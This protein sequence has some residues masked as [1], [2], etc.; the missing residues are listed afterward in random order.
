MTADSPPETNFKSPDKIFICSDFGVQLA[1]VVDQFSVNFAMEY[2]I[3]DR[4]TLT[5]LDS[6]INVLEDDKQIESLV[7]GAIPD[8]LLMIVRESGSDQS[9][10]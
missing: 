7:P 10:R 2:L 4:E 8:D 5:C 9:F 3:Q 6:L 1:F